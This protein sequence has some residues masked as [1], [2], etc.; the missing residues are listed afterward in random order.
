MTLDEILQKDYNYI[1][2]LVE[3]DISPRRQK[4]AVF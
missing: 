4:A 2:K 1:K 3:E